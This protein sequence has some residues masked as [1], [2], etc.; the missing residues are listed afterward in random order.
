[1]I[2]LASPYSHASPTVRQERYEAARDYTAQCIHEGQRIF[3]PIVYAH[4]L[5]IFHN[6]PFTADY[7]EQF[8][9][10][11]ILAAGKVRVLK[12]SG[13]DLSLGVRSEIALA[14]GLSIPVEYIPWP[15]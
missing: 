12:L 15:E 6:L 2:Y 1:M 7:W 9:R 5:A 11:M 8:N 13:W 4:E 3:S 14:T 10:E